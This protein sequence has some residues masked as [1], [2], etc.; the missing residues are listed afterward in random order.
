MLKLK[1]DIYIEKKNARIVAF[2]L[3]GLSMDRLYDKLVVLLLCIPGVAV[4]DESIKPVVV[5]LILLVVL[6]VVEMTSNAVMLGAI[7]VLFGLSFGVLPELF[8]GLPALMYCA[9]KLEKWYLVFLGTAVII[10]PD[11]L[12]S[13]EIFLPITAAA[14]ECI[15]Y[16][17]VNKLEKSGKTLVFTR[18][19]AKETSIRL[20]R[21][22]ADLIQ[23][24]DTEVY[25][26]TLKERNRIAREIH[27]N[28]GHMLTR[29]L[30]Q[31]GAIN[32]IN[33]DE[34]LKE[35]LA[36]LK[37]T[38]DEAMRNVRRSVHDIYDD[39]MDIESVIQE[40]I[41][42]L[43]K[44]YDVEFDFDARAD[45]PTKVKLCIAGIVK[46]SISNI[47]RHS[48][49]DRVRITVREHPGLYQ[50]IVE[51][52]GNSGEIQNTGIG[53]ENMRQRAASVN[54]RISFEASESG[55]KVFLSIPI[56]G[57]I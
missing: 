43:D 54:G 6:S 20:S 51:D 1:S 40:S 24:Q 8:A 12:S 15:F 18:D 37:D 42:S 4:S 33:K 50:L 44:D 34:T 45:M 49:G 31:A 53:L 41:Q 7:T 29:S 35:P 14:V 3:K 17:R 28:V 52:N 38:L 19:R 47:V 26:A 13:L 32:V 10:Q 27:D 48:N 57:K 23:M 11:G 56:G 30:L 55:F 36:E 21:K 2:L 5:M 39:S 46:E 16:M 25:M 22:N 9:L